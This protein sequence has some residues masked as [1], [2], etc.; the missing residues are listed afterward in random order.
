M[1]LTGRADGPPLAGGHGAAVLAEAL[2]AAIAAAQPAGAPRP[3]GAE[4]LAERATSTGRTRSGDV[5]VGGASRLLPTADGHV[6]L[7]LS[8]AE[9]L[10]LIPALV[11][12]EP[13]DPTAE[14]RWAAVA[15]WCR[16]R[17][18]A[19][20]VARA[21]LLGLPVGGLDE[22]PGG[23]RTLDVEQGGARRRTDRPLVV[24]LTSLWAGPLCAHLLA[25]AGAEVV[26]VESPRRRDG[27]RAG[28]PAFF[29]RLH[30]GVRDVMLDL[31]APEGLDRLHDLVER[32][33]VVLTG[34]RAAALARL[35][36]DPRGSAAGGA[37]WIAIT[38]HGLAD[39]ADRVGF[40]DDVAVAAGLVARDAAGPVFAAD[41]VADPLTGLAAAAAA[42]AALRTP[43]GWLVDVAMVRVARAA[44]VAS[45]PVERQGIPA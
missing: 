2:S 42:L 38:A 40:G 21:R 18:T 28:D 34:S 37:V 6:A 11:E 16:S 33:D 7:T 35:G 25:R 36:L 43:T 29:R 39:Q 22:D 5:S 19:D 1:A 45:R 8:R 41:A 4:V 30:A 14:G 3:P 24:D 31:R 20:V 44:A 10:E 23:P 15:D 27:A 26:K 32:A 12:R 13:V 9:D 17:P